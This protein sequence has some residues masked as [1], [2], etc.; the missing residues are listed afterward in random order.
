VL[1][2]AFSGKLFASSQVADLKEPELDE[3]A[4]TIESGEL[5]KK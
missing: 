3:G 5:R 2:Q 1:R 4:I